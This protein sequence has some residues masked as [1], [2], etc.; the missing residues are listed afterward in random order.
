MEKLT[1]RAVNIAVLLQSDSAAQAPVA[2]VIQDESDGRAASQLATHLAQGQSEEVH[3]LV[4]QQSAP[5][6]KGPGPA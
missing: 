5:L 2:C 1:G 4:V 3:I 6:E